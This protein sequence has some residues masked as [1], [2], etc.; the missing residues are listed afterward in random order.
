MN[1]SP[2][3]LIRNE[4]YKSSEIKMIIASNKKNIIFRFLHMNYIFWGNYKKV[5]LLFI[6]VY[7]TK[8]FYFTFYFALISKFLSL[9]YI[10]IIHGGNIE[11]RIKKSKWMTKYI[12]KNSNI[13]ISPSIYVNKPKFIKLI[14]AVGKI[15][16]YC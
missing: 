7:S 2:V 13:N 8:A 15:I 1:P 3:E 6:D 9:K 11:L 4:I 10:P 12:F 16:F 14:Q 5:S